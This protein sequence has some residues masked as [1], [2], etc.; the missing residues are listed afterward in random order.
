MSDILKK[1][2]N[3]SR[4]GKIATLE[5]MLH[6]EE[7]KKEKYEFKHQVAIEKLISVKK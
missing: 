5:T 3:C 1:K 2:C 6:Q 4:N 7:V